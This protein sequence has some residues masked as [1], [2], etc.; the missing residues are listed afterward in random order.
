MLQVGAVLLEKIDYAVAELGMLCN[1]FV[2]HD[3]V[4]FK[5]ER[6]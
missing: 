6:L 2:W 3:K 4:I 5:R 1:E